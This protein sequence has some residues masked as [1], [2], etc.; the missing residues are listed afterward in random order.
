[1]R[2]L[3]MAFTKIDEARRM[4]YGCLAEDAP[5]K[6]G[7]IFDYA[8][9]KPHVEAWSA[10]QQKNS[11]GMNFGNVRAMH[12]TGATAAG[13]MVDLT[14]DD[15]ARTIKGTAYISDDQEWRKV[16]A[17]TYTGFSMEGDFVGAKWRDPSTGFRRYTAKPYAVVLADNPCMYGATFEWVKTDG[18]TE[19]RPFRRPEDPA[20]EQT[21]AK[22]AGKKKVL[23]EGSTEA[24]KMM[25]D[26]KAFVAAHSLLDGDPATWDFPKMAAAISGVIG[27]DE[28]AEEAA[29]EEA[30]A[31]V[32]DA[33]AATA[34]AEGDA[35]MTA[36]VEP[37]ATKTAGAGVTVVTKTDGTG[38]I[39]AKATDTGAGAASAS[40]A[41]LDG[42]A[43]AVALQAESLKTLTGEAFAKTIETIV[44]KAIGGVTEELRK[45]HESIADLK[46]KIDKFPAAVGRPIRKV[47]GG[48]E[49]D[50]TPEGQVTANGPEA[51]R[52][53]V[54]ALIGTG[55]VS[56]NSEI[57]LRQGLA[58]LEIRKTQ[59]GA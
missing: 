55:Q 20:K 37:D 43:K 25:M 22:A 59:S 56:R 44:A 15:D 2:P 26:L 4:V 47:I 51:M 46:G 6:Q 19:V 45:A 14:F 49:V 21:M 38:T 50:V 53:V 13:Q 30:A 34:A 28:P 58:I 18:S 35:A 31:P 32:V 9:S 52:K 23:K 7:E 40:D 29:P 27:S 24:G 17:R 33:A 3:F 48:V 42:L 11:G 36:T 12:P 39:P 1:M 16:M 8:S 54:D 57:E 5:D 10:T 41:K